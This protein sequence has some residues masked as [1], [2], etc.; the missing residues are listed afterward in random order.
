M[1][2]SSNKIKFACEPNNSFNNI[3]FESKEGKYKSKQSCINDCDA[4]YIS[5]N[6]AEAG[7]RNETIQYR[8][9]I[10]KMFDQNMLVYI[11]G[12]TVLGL[13][14]L[15]MITN[16]KKHFKTLFEKFLQL[17]LIR[18]WDFCAYTQD[19]VLDIHYKKDL[20]K[21][22]KDDRLVSRAKTFILYQTNKPIQLEEQALF[23]IAILEADGYLG[24][25]LPLSTMKVKVH[26]YNLK[27]IFM[28]AKMFYR[29]KI[30]AEQIDTDMILHIM[31]HINIVIYESR[32]GLFVKNKDNFD[33]SGISEKLVEF[34]EKFSSKDLNIQ[35]FLITHLC[36]PNRMLYRL[37]EKNIPKSIKIEKFIKQHN[38]SK[39]TPNW[40]LDTKY[41]IKLITDFSIVFGKELESI[42]KNGFKAVDEF[43][44]GINF[45]RIKIEYDKFSDVAKQFLL[46]MFARIEK[47][48]KDDLP[49][50]DPNSL[51]S[52]IGFLRDKQL[53]TATN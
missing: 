30:K 12:G 29:Y 35:Q 26:P 24:L 38:L 28:L 23:E 13:K 5:R 34:V 53:F 21:L 47:I 32:N 22:A 15:K 42:Y 18:D 43:C 44:K 25:E 39:N 11:K 27:Y 49:K 50:S 33:T 51:W 36:E 10:S 37:L 17:D 46:N 48:V 8:S 7:I 19:K 2:K 6:L 52:A 14:I 4:K 20:E 31:S 3:C 41:I 40:L 1:S 16:N 9:F 45:K